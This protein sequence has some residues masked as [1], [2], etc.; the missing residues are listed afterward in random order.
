MTSEFS[1]VPVLPAAVEL[2]TRTDPSLSMPAPASAV[3]LASVLQVIAKM[4]SLA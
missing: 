2:L 4:P 3:L 1:V